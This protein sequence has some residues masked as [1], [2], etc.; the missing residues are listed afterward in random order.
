MTQKKPIEPGIVARVAQGIRYVISGVAPD[1]WFGPL[2]PL[3]P[4]AQD[5][6]WGRA[7]DYRTGSNLQYKPRGEEA[8]SFAQMR[9]LAD[10]YD[11]LRI[12]IETRKDQ[13]VKLKWDVR[14]IDE[15]AE[16]D[17][18]CDEVA[19][20]LKFPDK[21][22]GW[23]QW[24]RLVLED[25]LVVDA[26]SVLPRMNRGGGLYALELIDG[27][28]I[29]RVID[30]TGRTPM[31]PDPAYQQVLHGLVAVDYT[32]DQMIYFPRNVRTNKLYGYSPVEQILITVNIAIRRQL[33]QL[34]FYTD[35]NVPNLIFQVPP[36]WSVDQI[37]G[38]QEFWDSLNAGQSKHVGRFVPNGVTPFDTKLGALKDEYD[39]WLARICC[40]ALSIPATPFIKQNNRA[41][42]DSVKAQAEEEGLAPVQQYIVDLMNLILWRFF[43]YT[44]LTFAWAEE[45]ELDPDIQSQILDRGVRNGT[46]TLNEIRELNG[47]EAYA[48]EIGDVAMVYTATGPIPID[49]AIE[50]AQAS[51]EASQAG[52]DALAAG[53]GKQLADDKKPGANPL[54]AKLDKRANKKK[55]SSRSIATG[56]LLNAAP[57]NSSVTY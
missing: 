18:R 52:T 15:D 51:L 14:P 25:M 26:V 45:E 6:A 41:V 49:K 31:P 13:M 20:F 34:S 21:E 55:V 38:F 30:D 33:N 5:Q 28:T 17:N 47:D 23:Q 46:K 40:F 32:R 7:F 22:H 8:V 57:R 56:L 4:A 16:R 9:A 10:G 53:D 48:P 50:Q 27:A 3:Q 11:L 42:A 12:L 2:Q 35:G 39:E 24:L 37:K 29:K 36:E 44:D 43:G 54:A 1:S 19:D